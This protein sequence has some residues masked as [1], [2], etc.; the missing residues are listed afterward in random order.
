MIVERLEAL[1]QAAH[2]LRY[3]L[4]TDTSFRNCLTTMTV[5]ELAPSQP[6]LAWSATFEVDGLPASE[7]VEMLEG[8][9]AADCV[10]LKHVLE[11]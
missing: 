6:E 5:R 7:A 9:L 10:G 11:R 2:W 4:L 3:S 8:T 1:D